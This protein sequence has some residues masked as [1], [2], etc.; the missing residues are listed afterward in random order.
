MAGE[1]FDPRLF[2]AGEAAGENSGG[3]GDG[4]GDGLGVPHRGLPPAPEL[5]FPPHSERSVMTRSISLPLKGL[6]TCNKR[7]CISDWVIRHYLLTWNHL[8]I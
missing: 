5:T 8:K 1:K 4:E 3:R 2:P 6:T 7:G